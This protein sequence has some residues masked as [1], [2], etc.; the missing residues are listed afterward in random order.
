MQRT[1]SA[2][3]FESFGSYSVNSTTLEA[4]DHSIT[5]SAFNTPTL[6]ATSS[7]NRS[8]LLLFY[9]YTL[10]EFIE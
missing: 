5:Y 2:S 8:G 6:S 4:Q 9:K 10:S 7:I 1:I 3:S